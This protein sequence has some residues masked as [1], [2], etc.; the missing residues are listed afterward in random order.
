MKIFAG[1]VGF[2]FLCAVGVIAM[3][4]V[5]TESISGSGLGGGVGAFFSALPNVMWALVI[6]AIVLLFVGLLGA[7]L[8]SR[9]R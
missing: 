6:G 1:L 9:L 8:F 3:G 4:P 2:T 7:V 5:M